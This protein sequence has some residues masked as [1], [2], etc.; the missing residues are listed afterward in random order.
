MCLSK[1]ILYQCFIVF[2]PAWDSLSSENILYVMSLHNPKQKTKKKSR[3]SAPQKLLRFFW[4][5]MDMCLPTFIKI[6]ELQIILR[7]I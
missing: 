7:A 3:L 1:N 5:L 4:I 2:C 6:Q